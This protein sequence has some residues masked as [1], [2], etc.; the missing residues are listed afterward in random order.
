M[1]VSLSIKEVPAALAERLRQR[2]ARNHRSLQRELMALVEAAVAE[3][4]RLPLQA[5]EPQPAYAAAPVRATRGVEADDDLLAA[6]DAVVAGSH[7]GS[8][9]LLSR[10]QL[11]DRALARELDFDC[12]EA[13]L[14]TARTATKRKA[15]R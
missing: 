13:E 15:G 10:E 3:A 7:W 6:L 8:A 4:P 11:H 2:A 1:A 12:R 9:P 14:R 5:R